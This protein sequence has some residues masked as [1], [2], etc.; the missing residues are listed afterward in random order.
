MHDIYQYM[1]TLYVQQVGWAFLSK[2][3]A[4]I[5]QIRYESMFRGSRY[6]DL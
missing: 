4:E 1:H 5:H 3:R 2:A 6:M